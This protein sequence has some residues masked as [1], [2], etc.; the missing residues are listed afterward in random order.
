MTTTHRSRERIG[1]VN[2][3][4]LEAVTTATTGGGIH[5]EDFDDKT[6][7]VNV[8]VNTGAVTVTIQSSPDN[9]TW[10]DVWEK[11]YT[12]AVAKDVASFTDQFPW[13]RTKTSTQ[14]S[15][16]VSTVITARS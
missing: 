2:H 4:D 11:T 16:T 12:S 8:S 6:V 13:M 9:S 3:D 5:V 14:S 15:S 10:Y 1:T 7:F